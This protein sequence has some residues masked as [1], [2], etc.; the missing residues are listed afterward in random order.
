MR[1]LKAHLF[2]V[3]TEGGFFRRDPRTP[4]EGGR[5]GPDQRVNSVNFLEKEVNQ[6]PE[7]AT[8][9]KREK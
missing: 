2:S 6:P 3:G 1:C 9:G 5:T 8:M 7:G 4:E